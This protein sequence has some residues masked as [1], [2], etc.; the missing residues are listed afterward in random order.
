MFRY[1]WLVAALKSMWIRRC[2]RVVVA[3]ASLNV[4]AEANPA[5]PTV[6]RDFNGPDIAWQILDAGVPARLLAH[7]LIPTGA[8]DSSGFERVVVAGPAGQSVML[9]FPIAPV[10][11]L[12]E[13][14]ARLWVR[15]DHPGV[16]LAF[17]VAL[18]RSQQPRSDSMAT[19]M[20]RGSATSHP[21]HWQ[22]LVISDVP[23]LLAD[24]VRVMRTTAGT[25]I[26]P[27]EAFVDA[28]VLVVPGDPKGVE[29]ATDALEVNGV[30]VPS[31]S[32]SRPANPTAN[33]APPP[34]IAVRTQTN[35]SNS[36][37]GSNVNAGA[38]ASAQRVRMQGTTLLV[39]GKLFLPRV[40]EWRGEPLQF[41]SDCGFNVVQLQDAPSAD[42][43][44]QAERLGMWF[45]CPA[46]S[47]DEIARAGLGRAGD[48]VL[49]W[50]LHDDAIDVDPNHTLHWAAQI[51]ERDAEFGRPVVMSPD[52]N[53]EIAAKAADSLIARNPRAAAMS[54]P[55]LEGW[56]DRQWRFAR[57]GQPVWACL[58]TQFDDTTRGQSDALSHVS[59]PAPSVDAERLESLVR[60]AGLRGAH[61]F[62][63]LSNSMLSETDA[64]T[65]RRAAELELLNRRLELMTPWLVAGKIVGQVTSTDSK[66]TGVVLHVDRARLLVPAPELVA[67]PARS[68]KSGTAPPN[69]E[70]VVVI[71]GVPESSQVFLLSP[72]AMRSVSAQR[73]AGGIRVALPS[74]DSYVLMT[75]DPQIIRSLRERI[76]NDGPRA[77]RLERE[78]TAQRAS[79]ILQTTAQLAQL[80]HKVDASQRDLATVNA[81]I[82]GVDALLT[83]GQLEAA[84]ELAHATNDSM[85]RMMAEERRMV[86]QRAPFET[87]PLG[88]NYDR[89]GDYAAWQRSAAALSGG[90][91]ILIGGDFED[92]T[93]MSQA[94][95]QHIN[96]ELPGIETK[97]DLSAV[98]PQHGN[99]CLELRSSMA[100]NQPPEAALID[101]PVW[102][103]TPPMPVEAGQTIQIN[104]WIRVETPLAAGDGLQIVDSIGGP[105]LSLVIRNTD[106]WQPFEMIRSARASADLRLTFALIGLGTAKVD[107]VM[108]RTLQQPLARRLP[109]AES[110]ERPTANAAAP[111]P[112]SRLPA[113]R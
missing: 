13:L 10:A 98:Q 57:P 30:L 81:Q 7:D 68:A 6:S 102:I 59:Q 61:G 88:V 111:D 79:L 49:A 80:G 104:G 37:A 77:G 85:A 76:A 24:Q 91:N 2:A 96:R 34:N 58:A 93:Q 38:A 1:N 97:A 103:V 19:A 5:A 83:A 43:V 22:Q 35:G 36:S 99:Y 23:K 52:S 70:I 42:D 47:L 75:E 72:A 26:D 113:P 109:S 101:A 89:L 41:L 28:V 73:V 51:R 60:I 106:G 39:D 69:S 64:A 53:W 31:P 54:G 65:R 17:R 27:R 71:P 110:T 9:Q 12:D 86:L 82:A 15:A 107:A 18:P 48:R 90:Q 95:W 87:N 33:G 55:E 112:I 16:Q 14:Q 66:W 74:A 56:I 105:E 46:P 100:P 29:V 3:A 108:V 63:F 32:V 44:A 92:I 78:L 40:I 67:T 45:I 62:V 50:S 8:P 21:G 20:V 94:G 4:S 25:T 84:Y 11:A